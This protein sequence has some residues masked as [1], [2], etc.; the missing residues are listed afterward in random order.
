MKT[1]LPWQQCWGILYFC[2]EHLS[3]LRCSV[4]TVS[5]VLWSVWIWTWGRGWPA[6]PG[7]RRRP[8]MIRFKVQTS[9][10]NSRKISCWQQK[11]DGMKW[12]LCKD[13][14]LVLTAICSCDDC[15]SDLWVGVIPGSAPSSE[16][17]IGIVCVKKKDAFLRIKWQ[18]RYHSVSTC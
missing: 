4:I 8:G 18:N 1:E 2:F 13:V 7:R 5:A 10:F 3:H 11:W 9:A 12:Q 15:Q 6:G 17:V 16:V 14:M